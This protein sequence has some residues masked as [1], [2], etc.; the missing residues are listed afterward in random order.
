MEIKREIKRL[1]R[2]SVFLESD[3][4]DVAVKNGRWVLTHLPAGPRP[5]PSRYGTISIPCR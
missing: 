2:K 4:F 3:K 5:A 1:R